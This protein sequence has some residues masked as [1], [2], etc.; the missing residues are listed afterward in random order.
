MGVGDSCVIFGTA[1][2]TGLSFPAIQQGAVGTGTAGQQG[3]F[4]RF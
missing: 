1:T 4:Q 3:V 2:K